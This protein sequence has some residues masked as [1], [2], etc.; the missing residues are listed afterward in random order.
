MNHLRS[1]YACNGD[2]ETVLLQT[3][4]LEFFENEIKARQKSI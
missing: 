2:E 1:F 3:R 4:I